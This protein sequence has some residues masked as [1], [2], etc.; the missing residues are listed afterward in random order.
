MI[1]VFSLIIAHFDGLQMLHKY[2]QDVLGCPQAQARPIWMC[3]E[4]M[5]SILGGGE[6]RQKSCEG[7]TDLSAY[8]HS[9]S[10]ISLASSCSKNISRVC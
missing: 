5:G 6:A 2:S 4:G 1:G 3:D 8:S 7:G 9:S 10:L